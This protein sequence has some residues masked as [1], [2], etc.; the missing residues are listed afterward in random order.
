MKAEYFENGK[1]LSTRAST[2]IVISLTTTV[3]TLKSHEVLHINLSYRRGIRILLRILAVLF[4]Y[5]R[6]FTKL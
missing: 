3:L 2:E 6:I 5:I 1:T 4:Y